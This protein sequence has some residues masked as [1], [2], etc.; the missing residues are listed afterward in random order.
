MVSNS[1]SNIIGEAVDKAIY[2]SVV[3]PHLRTNFQTCF[4]MC[5][6]VC[7]LYDCCSCAL[8]LPYITAMITKQHNLMHEK[9]PTRCRMRYFDID[10]RKSEV[11]AEPFQITFDHG[12]GLFDGV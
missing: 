11:V 6:I 9:N 1:D 2:Y 4:Y 3:V 7:L 10:D 5:Y 8:Q 12:K